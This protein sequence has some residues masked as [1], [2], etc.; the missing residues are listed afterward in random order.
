[1]SASE[2]RN[3]A[4]QWAPWLVLLLAALLVRSPVWTGPLDREF[5]GFQGGFFATT[6]V[7]YE[8][9]GLGAA[10]G[11]PVAN[12]ELDAERPSTWYV[13]PNHPPTVPLLAW[14]SARLFGPE[15]WR[16]AWREHRAPA[17]LEPALR[18]PFGLA[19]L[20]TA[21]GLAALLILAGQRT[22]A[23][24]AL[25]AFAF[26]PIEVGYAG[27]VNYEHPAMAAAV[28]TGVAVLAWCRTPSPARLAAC[29]L[30]GAA[31]TAVTFAPAFFLPGY[32]LLALRLRGWAAWKPTVA[33]GLGALTPI[34]LHRHFGGGVLAAFDLS[35]DPLFDRVRRLLAPLLDGSLPFGR[36]LAIQGESARVYLGP[37]LCAL[38]AAGLLLA[39]YRF[40][41]GPRSERATGGIVLA[42][43]AGGALAHVAFYKHTGDPQPSFLLNLAPGLAAAAG[44]ALAAGV[45]RQWPRR[46]GLAALAPAV[47]L[48]VLG[49]WRSDGLI[50]PWRAPASDAPGAPAIAPPVEI[51]AQLAARVPAGHAVWYP[52]SLGLNP[53]AFFY[54]WRTM[55]PVAPSD[56][57][58]AA[59]QGQL[60]RFDQQDL[61]VV[62][63][64]PKHPPKQAAAQTAALAARLA[65][66]YPEIHGAPLVD[67]DLWVI[68]RLR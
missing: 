32:A 34:L 3:R 35:P 11:Y 41:R 53:A 57:S 12:V 27:L 20:A 68:Y 1:M 59:A 56:A 6:A 28:W 39:A 29:A 23:P 44:L 19:Q 66:D 51:G 21:L 64:L 38:G 5:D 67:D 36:W 55:L 58:Y 22:A 46:A 25:A 45:E 61:P 24:L 10:D 8:R 50:T 40:L 48:A 7:N 14:V 47:L 37:E 42:L 63:A 9:L 16:D 54:A 26:A 18:L 15:G 13:Y 49:S 43:F 33:L 52:E 17:G 62:L 65:Q 4:L 2:D 60:E 31:G 30:G